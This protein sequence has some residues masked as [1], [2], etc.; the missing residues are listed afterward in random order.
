L[1]RAEP[2]WS[3]LNIPHLA[4]LPAVRWRLQNLQE[5]ARRSPAR[6]RALADT[7]DTHLEALPT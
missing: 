3:L 5:L 7:L 4:E 6:F 1:V 2:D